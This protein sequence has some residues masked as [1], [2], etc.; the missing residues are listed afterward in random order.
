[1]ALSHSVVTL[2]SSTATAL[3]TDS[4]VIN[5]V[6]GEKRY[7]WQNGSISIQNIDSTIT[8][9]IGSSGVTSSSFG[10]QLVAGASVTFDSLG[11]AEVLYAIAAS[12]TPKLAIMLVTT[13]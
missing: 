8:A 6:S 1:M 2:S 9:Y 13:A 12:G 7:T 11:P 10:V 4:V 5:A 3:N